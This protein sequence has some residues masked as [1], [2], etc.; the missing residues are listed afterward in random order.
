[1]ITLHTVDLSGNGLKARLLL[2]MLGLSYETKT[3]DMMKGE[4]KAPSFLA[5]NPLGQVPVLVDGGVTLRDSQAILVY[6][7]RKYGGEDWLPSDPATMGEVMQWLSFA[8]N[9]IAQGPNR[10][11]LAKVFKFNVDQELARKIADGAL[12]VLESRLTGRD[13]LVGSRPTIADLACYPY[14]ALAYEGGYDLAPYKAV[15]AWIKRVEALPGYVGMPGLP[16]AA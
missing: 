1:M 14:T 5:L 16:K 8:C 12:G 6:L 13:W 9:E 15:Q 2:S 7:A 4:H 11:R 3:P 10:L